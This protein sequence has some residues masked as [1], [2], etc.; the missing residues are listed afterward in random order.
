MTTATE[1]AETVSDKTLKWILAQIADARRAG[2]HNFAMTHHPVLPPS[3]IYELIAKGYADRRR[4]NL[5]PFADAGLEFIFTGHS[6]MQNIS[7]KPPKTATGFT[8]LTQLPCG[9]SES[10]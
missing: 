2:G 8:I 5:G 4:Q 3:P 6:H 7:V 10:H 1:K 9:L